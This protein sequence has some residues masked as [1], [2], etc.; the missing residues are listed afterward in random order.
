MDGKYESG[1]GIYTVGDVAL[2]TGLNPRTIREY[3]RRGLLK[4]EKTAAGWRFTAEQFVALISHPEVERSIRAKDQG[5]VLDFLSQKKKA[6]PAACVILDLPI[7]PD[8]EEGL[9]ERLLALN[10]EGLSFRYRQEGVMA[11]I[12]ATGSPNQLADL[13][14]EMAPNPCNRKD[15]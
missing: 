7:G 8:G 4:G 14:K 6:A 2:M 5:I 10:G 15:I 13:L 9:R 12:T 1:K 11:R 3:L